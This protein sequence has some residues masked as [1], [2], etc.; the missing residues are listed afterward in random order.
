MQITKA[1]LSLALFY[2]NYVLASTA[3]PPTEATSIEALAPFRVV[4]GEWVPLWN[5]LEDG[6]VLQIEG[7]YLQAKEGAN[8]VFANTNTT[9]ND[10]ALHI[11]FRG[12]ND[13]IMFNGR[14]GGKWA[15]DIFSPFTV[16]D[17]ALPRNPWSRTDYRKLTIK[18]EYLKEGKG[19]YQV[20]FFKYSD[21]WMFGEPETQV[22]KLPVRYKNL[23]SNFLY[24]E[25][26]GHGHLSN[27]LSVTPISNNWH[28]Y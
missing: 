8:I 15:G 10:Q 17:A 21:F 2:S 23:K 4:G 7:Y 6:Q 1:I 26:S 12:L 14:S 16:N 19:A 24:F 11:S 18:V 27:E 13:K 28:R 20:T 3:G 25:N 9:K 22:V 5:T